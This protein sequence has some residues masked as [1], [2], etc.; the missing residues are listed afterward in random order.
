[1]ER[2]SRIAGYTLV[3]I[4]IAIVVFT[5]GALA[6][7]ASSALIARS[8]ARNAERERAARI[9]VSRI[10]LVRSQCAIASSGRETL[11]QL[12]SDWVVTRGTSMITIVESV[13]C[14]GPVPCASYR[15]T[16]WCRA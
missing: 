8:M 14:L 11:E 9:G 5:I 1:M 15:A 10:E 7:T 4:V 6:L 12:Q 13:R 2:A 3:E 16:I